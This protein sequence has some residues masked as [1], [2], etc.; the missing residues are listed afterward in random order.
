MIEPN[1]WDY[2]II[3]AGILG[4]AVAKELRSRERDSSI[5]ILE[6][7]ESIGLH[8][9]G[10]NSGVLHSG[11][12]YPEGSLKAS[13]CA[14]GSALMSNYCEEKE[15][16]INRIGKIILPIRES[17]GIQL[18]LLH[19]RAIANNAVAEVID[20]KH[21]DE[22]EPEAKSITG[23]A[24]FSPNTSV[25]DPV[26]ILERLKKDLEEEKVCFMFK[27]ELKN[28]DSQKSIINVNNKQLHYKILVN[29]AGQHADKIAKIFNVGL[30]FVSIPF[31]GSYYKL[32]QRSSVHLKHLV[33][34]VPDLDMPFLGIHSVTTINGETYFGPSAIPAFGREHYHGTSGINLIDGLT[35]VRHLLNQYIK[36]SQGM[37]KY[38]HEEIGNFYKVGFIKTCQKMI[39]NL[40]AEDLEKS[41]KVGI[42]AQLFDVNKNKFEMDFVVKRKENTIH[43]LN[44]VS[45]AF[46]SAFSMSKLIL[47]A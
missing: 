33:Y 18:K 21:L 2:V 39:P 3:G 25:V 29:V 31:R 22:I 6:K 17:D 24:L 38:T 34:P 14:S 4:L 7:E 36:N 26:S 44:A 23:N 11:I 30:Q 15:L 45:P 35:S 19:D 13:I 1:S 42:R 41:R 40:K 10:R 32:S 47:D 5:L 28:V 9:S 46:T 37:R 12:Y 20:S 43:V 16:P 8:A 27:S